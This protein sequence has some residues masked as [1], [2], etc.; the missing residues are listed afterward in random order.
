MEY[1]DFL[2]FELRNDDVFLLLRLAKSHSGLSRDRT[3]GELLGLCLFMTS[4]G[5]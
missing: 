4:P 5:T 1:V 3:T 2:E